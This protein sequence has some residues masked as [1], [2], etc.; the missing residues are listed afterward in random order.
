MA[1]SVSTSSRS[2]EG[3]ERGIPGH[4]GGRVAALLCPR[5]P[6][7]R[8][9][10]LRG[11]QQ[12]SPAVGCPAPRWQLR[13]IDPGEGCKQGRA[14]VSWGG[15]PRHRGGG[16]LNPQQHRAPLAAW[17]SPPVGSCTTS[18][19][20]TVCRVCQVSW[21]EPSPDGETEAQGIWGPREI[22]VTAPAQ[23]GGA[24]Q[25][26]QPPHHPQLQAL[27]V[28]P[29]HGPLQVKQAPAVGA[30]PGRAGGTGLG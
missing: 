14:L 2:C 18:S 11:A 12:G 26:A 9:A 5:P 6:A 7:H 20:V 28:G 17:L 30:Q 13:G 1:A 25:H 8:A 4:H 10:A 23:P 15:G 16:N 24:A 19:T 21:G 3:T 22:S 29:S 27:P